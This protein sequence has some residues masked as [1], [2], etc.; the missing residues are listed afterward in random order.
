MPKKKFEPGIYRHTKSGKL[1][2]ALTWGKN[3][4]NPKEEF[5]VYI[6][7]YKRKITDPPL[8]IRPLPMF[9]EKVR[10]GAKLFPR[11]T[12][13]EAVSLMDVIEGIARQVKIKK[14]A[15]K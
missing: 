1:Y 15:A 11:F 5:V 2:Y 4:E 8:W 7:L 10:I 9:R 3:S 12:F 6:P 14:R 13:I